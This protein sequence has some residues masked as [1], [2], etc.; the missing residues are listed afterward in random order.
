MPRFLCDKIDK[1]AATKEQIMSSLVMSSPEAIA[2]VYQTLLLTISEIVFVLAPVYKSTENDSSS[3]I[4]TPVDFI[5]VDT[6]AN[7]EKSLEK[8]RNEIIGTKISELNSEHFNLPTLSGVWETALHISRDYFIRK[9]QPMW[10]RQTVMPFENGIMVISLPTS[11]SDISLELALIKHTLNETQL[12]IREAGHDVRTPLTIIGTSL[13]LAQ[14]ITDENKRLELLE[15]AKEQLDRIREI[16][17]DLTNFAKYEN[18]APRLNTN[19]IEV[20]FFVSGIYRELAILLIEKN[21]S[22]TLNLE[23]QGAVNIDTEKMYRAIMNIV[24]NA[25]TY[26]PERGSIYIKTYNR[27]ANDIVIEIADTGIGI[28]EEEIDN[29]FKK[30]YRINKNTLG[31]GLGLSISKKIVEMH[32]GKIEVTSK[33]GAGSTFSLVLPRYVNDNMAI[34][35]RG[36]NDPIAMLAKQNNPVV[37]EEK[38]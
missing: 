4:T 30:F 7:G 10:Y 11:Q 9:A 6:N 31:L 27:S 38:V 13:Y 26:T 18:N 24:K 3:D 15:R 28:A 23:A 37:I 17:D 16:I 20:N 8:P 35:V 25:V 29:I 12:A 1:Y 21:Q 22:M 34:I 14:K 32:H 19:P 36:D 5:I 2:A 33:V